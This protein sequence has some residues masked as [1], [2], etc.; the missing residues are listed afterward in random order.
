M[1]FETGYHCDSLTMSV[2]SLSS[3]QGTRD[4]AVGDQGVCVC[5]LEVRNGII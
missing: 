4:E 5:V 2:D 3:Q 1:L